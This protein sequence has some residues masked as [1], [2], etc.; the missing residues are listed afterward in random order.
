MAKTVTAKLKNRAGAATQA[1][2]AP[3]IHPARIDVRAGDRYHVHTLAGQ[4][5]EARLADGVEKTFAEECLREHRTV[6]VTPQARTA[7]P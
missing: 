4:R 1:S 3:G 5:V 6:L 7:S 2:L